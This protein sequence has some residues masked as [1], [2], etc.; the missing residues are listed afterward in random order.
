MVR[1]TKAE[2]EATRCSLLDAA[3]HLFHA[4]GVS[5]TSLQDIALAA[6][7]TR[8]AIYWHF[9]DKG[10]L[11]NAMMDRVCLPMEQADAQ[12]DHMSGSEPLDRMRQMLLDTLAQVS[13]DTQVRRVFE[14]ATY[15]VEYVDELQV[16][17]QRHLKAVDDHRATIRRCLERSGMPSPAAARHAMGLHVT[18]VG[19]IHTWMLCDGSFDLVAEGGHIVD[20]YIAGM[21]S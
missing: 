2:A 13:S 9:K 7:V 10:D 18:L 12:L 14:I 1:R 6:G 17:R 3:E 21:R 19:L 4:Q 8:G 20:T 16:V 15:K 5:R 11:F